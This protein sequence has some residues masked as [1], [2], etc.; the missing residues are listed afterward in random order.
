MLARFVIGSRSFHQ[1]RRAPATLRARPACRRRGPRPGPCRPQ[2]GRG[3]PAPASRSAVGLRR[4]GRS[5][6]GLTACRRRGPGRRRPRSGRAVRRRPAGDERRRAAPGRRG[7]ER[8]RQRRA[9]AP[10]RSAPAPGPRR[11]CRRLCPPRAASAAAFPPRPRLRAPAGRPAAPRSRPRAVVLAAPA[12]PPRSGSGRPGCRSLAGT[13]RHA[14]HLGVLVVLRGLE[15][16]QR[17]AAGGSSSSAAFSRVSKSSSP[18]RWTAPPRRDTS[19]SVSVRPRGKSGAGRCASVSTFASASVFSALTNSGS[20]SARRDDEEA[21]GGDEPQ[22]A[23]EI[24]DGF[25]L[26]NGLRAG[27]VTVLSTTAPCIIVFT[28]KGLELSAQG[29][30]RSERTLGA[31]NPTAFFDP[32]RVG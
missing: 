31:A 6:P 1:S 4:Q 32:E 19:A 23:P 20:G 29:R 10:C 12:P 25:S 28:P 8:S 24:H 14:A 5:G 2:S 3:L 22:Q 18:S 30:S 26:A 13:G 9:A 16:R 27:S 11:A 17:L 15:E 7:P 21:E